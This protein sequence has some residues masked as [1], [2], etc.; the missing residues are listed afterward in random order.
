MNALS[1]RTRCCKPG[2]E[3]APFRRRNDPRHDVEGNQPLGP[4][5][6]AVHGEGDAD[7][8]EQRVGFGALLCNALTR[9]A[10]QPG[11]ECAVVLADVAIRRV[12]L[13]VC[14]RPDHRLP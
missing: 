5:L 9:R 13:V 4:G 12:H 11:G 8:M 1:A 3:L 10:R 7:T 14:G 6:L 2:G